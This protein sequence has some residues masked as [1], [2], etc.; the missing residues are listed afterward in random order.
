MCFIDFVL[1]RGENVLK[2][3]QNKLFVLIRLPIQ[4]LVFTSKTNAH[5]EKYHL[6]QNNIY[7]NGIEH[8]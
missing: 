5:L 1:E 4:V 2:I 8:I 6:I 3:E 7:S